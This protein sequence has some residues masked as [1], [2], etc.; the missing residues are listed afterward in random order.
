[1]RNRIEIKAIFCVYQIQDF[2]IAFALFK[3]IAHCASESDFA[4]T[5]GEH[6][7]NV[8]EGTEQTS[9]AMVVIRHPDYNP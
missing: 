6:N 2:K 8:D 7:L 9:R 4:V 5:A 3:K 1:M